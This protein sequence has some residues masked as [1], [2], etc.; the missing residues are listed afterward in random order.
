MDELSKS[1]NET[2]KLKRIAGLLDE[3][4][5][6]QDDLGE[7]DYEDEEDDNGVEIHYDSTDA[8]PDFEILDF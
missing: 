2:E 6:D 1:G 8:K 4:D 7:D 3:Y 5:D